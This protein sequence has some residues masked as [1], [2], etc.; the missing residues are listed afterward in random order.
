M[1]TIRLHI[2]GQEHDTIRVVNRGK[3]GV[4]G[5]YRYDAVCQHGR[6]GVTHMREEGAHALAYVVL[7]HHEMMTQG[8]KLQESKARPPS[9]GGDAA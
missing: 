9:N 6:F 5:A 4:S 3:V 8:Q 2:G 1:L 7:R